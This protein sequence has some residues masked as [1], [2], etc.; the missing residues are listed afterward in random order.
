[1]EPE[2][3]GSDAAR[4]VRIAAIDDEMSQQIVSALIEGL[5]GDRLSELPPP[6][7]DVAA[8]MCGFDGRTPADDEQIAAKLGI[9]LNT[10]RERAEQAFA[11]LRDLL[12]EALTATPSSRTRAKAFRRLIP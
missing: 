10:A 11:H 5:V 2:H 1:M 3:E 9:P 8:L 4:N 7:Q 6:L 12:V